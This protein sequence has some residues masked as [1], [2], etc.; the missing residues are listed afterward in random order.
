M[1]RPHFPDEEPEAQRGLR[2]AWGFTVDRE[3]SWHL[4][5]SSPWPGSEEAGTALG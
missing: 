4:N 5:L 3:Q 2:L 1:Q